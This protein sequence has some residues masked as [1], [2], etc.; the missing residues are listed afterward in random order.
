MVSCVQARVKRT[1][2]GVN[3]V[4][5]RAV[6]PGVVDPLRWGIVRRILY[7]TVRRTSV[8]DL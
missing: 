3:L 1:F 6:V 8:V 4:L 7:T 5:R 2:A